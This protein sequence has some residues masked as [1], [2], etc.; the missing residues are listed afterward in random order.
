MGTTLVVAALVRDQLYIANVGDSRA[1]LVSDSRVYQI[2]RDHSWVAEQVR[3]GTIAAGV[4][5]RHP[6]RNVLT[7]AIGVSDNVAPD[8]TTY[9]PFPAI[10]LCSVPTDCTAWS[11]T[12]K[13]AP[14]PRVTNQIRPSTL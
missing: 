7:R 11:T 12:K 3:A 4:A 5:R 2:T 9:E 10:A 8:V 1:Y 13:S 14:L 6:R